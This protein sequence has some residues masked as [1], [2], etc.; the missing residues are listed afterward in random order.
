MNDM[1]PLDYAALYAHASAQAGYFTT[2]QARE[3]G[4]S[5]RALAHHATRGRFRRVRRGLYRFRDY[6]SSLHEEVVAA[7]LSMGADRSVVSHDTALDLYDLTD[8]IPSSVHLIVPRAQRGLHPPTG[9]T[10]HTTTRLLRDDEVTI[11]EGVRLTTPERTLLDLAE[12]GTGLEHVERG[13]QNAL[14]RGW[15]DAAHLRRAA[16]ERGPRVSRMVVA[17]LDV[18]ERSA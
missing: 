6:P 12:G 10:L 8:L 2:T 13:I 4:I 5:G 16:M 7:W 18:E 3:H 17:A 11:R 14:A 9:V 1:T 15:L